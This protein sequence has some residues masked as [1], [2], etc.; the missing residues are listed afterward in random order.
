[1][2]EVPILA[3][4]GGLDYIFGV[5]GPLTPDHASDEALR[6]A[7]EYG[8]VVP[9]RLIDEIVISRNLPHASRQVIETI[10]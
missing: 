4:S 1:M 10:G 7:K 2:L 5:H 9:V 8:S 3:R 6:D